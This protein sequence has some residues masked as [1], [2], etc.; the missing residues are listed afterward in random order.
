M[1]IIYRA[2]GDILSIASS[3]VHRTWQLD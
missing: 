1:S 3:A 2:D